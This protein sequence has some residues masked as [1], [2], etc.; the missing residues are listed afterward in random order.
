KEEHAAARV[1]ILGASAC[2]SARILL[3]T[4]TGK[5]PRGLGNSSGH[6]GRWLTD[7]T[8]SDLGGQ[9]PALE[10]MPLHNE[11]GVSTMHTYAP[12]MKHDDALAGK[13]GFPRGYYMFWSGG[14]TM[15]GLGSLSGA[16]GLA[17]DVF[18]KKLKDEARRYYG[19]LVN[20]GARGEMVANEKSYLAL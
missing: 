3:N 2:E 11:D 19:S 17:G 13:L 6:L 14:R 18:G 10:N 8:G 20:I 12:W 4:R 15:P 16:L 7:S 5:F 1:V 9:I